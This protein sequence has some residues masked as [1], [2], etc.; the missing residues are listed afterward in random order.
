MVVYCFVVVSV[1]RRPGRLPRSTRRYNASWATASVY[2]IQ[3]SV[4]PPDHQNTPSHDGWLE[5]ARTSASYALAC[6]SELGLLRLL[7]LLLL[8]LP[9]L[10]SL[11]MLIAA[12]R[13]AFAS[14]PWTA[15]AYFAGRRLCT[16]ADRHSDRATRPLHR[17]SARGHVAVCVGVCLIPVR[18][19]VFGMVGL[20]VGD[21]ARAG[22]G[23][24]L[25]LL[26]AQLECQS[27][28]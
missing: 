17:F 13:R 18:N 12:A 20:T 7:S 11:W 22:V 14:A 9:L 26:P 8:L 25:V 2:G 3:R 27:H 16:S 28:W 19:A 6:G 1:L 23:T 5:K 24:D 10:L 21:A 4:G 15:A